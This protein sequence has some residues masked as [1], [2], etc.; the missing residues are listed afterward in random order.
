MKD[1]AGTTSATMIPVRD[2]LR[3]WVRAQCYPMV[4]RR[5]P[6]LIGTSG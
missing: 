5:K 6:L 1:V 4:A 2:I 3:R